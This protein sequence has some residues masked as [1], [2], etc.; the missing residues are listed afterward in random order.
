MAT[1]KFDDIGGVMLRRKEDDKNTCRAYKGE[2]DKYEIVSRGDT[3]FEIDVKEKKINRC[4][5]KY[6]CKERGGMLFIRY[7]DALLNR[8]FIPTTETFYGKGIP[9]NMKSA[10]VMYNKSSYGLLCT[11]M[12]DAVNRLQRINDGKYF[13]ALKKGDKIYI[14]NKEKETV[15]EDTIEFVTN[16]NEWY[17]D[18]KH[19]NIETEKHHFDCYHSEY[20]E[21]A[22]RF[23]DENFYA[24]F[25]NVDDKKISIHMDRVVAEKVLREYLSSRKNVAKKKAETPKIPEGTPI[26]HK[27]NKG[28]D[29]HYGDTVSYVRKDHWGHTDISFG[30]IVGDSEKK[31]KIFDQEEKE[32]MEKKENHWTDKCAD[33][34]HILENSNVLLVK[35][36]KC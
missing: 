17:H 1:K 32:Y 25:R 12:E 28:N 3:L 5:A 33:G 2:E 11:N 13:G 31:I 26:R 14:V 22:S 21:N 36:A 19:F 6:V 7:C 23:S 20:E 9:K 29:L 16:D 27:D 4:V 24:H 10:Y 30:V 15:T 8:D 35:L 18:G 34:V